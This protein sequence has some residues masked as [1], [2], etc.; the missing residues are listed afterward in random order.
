MVKNI[1]A[2]SLL[3]VLCTDCHTVQ[4]KQNSNLYRID[5]YID[6][7]V[8]LSQ[9]TIL[10]GDTISVTVIYYNKSD[11]SFYFYPEA[12]L[13]ID[14]YNPHGIFTGEPR[15]YY[16]SKYYNLNSLFLLKNHENYSKTY[17]VVLN[18]PLLHLGENKL[19]VKYVCSIITRK[20]EQEQDNKIEY[21]IL[22]GGIQ[23]AAFEIYVK[24]K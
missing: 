12:L 23:S 3:F 16:L 2:L 15:S 21:E 22:Y 6:L 1:I 9:D 14:W 18:E 24:E 13:Y 7:H 4:A 10:L 19:I 5:N 20:Y 11:T 17:T 8:N